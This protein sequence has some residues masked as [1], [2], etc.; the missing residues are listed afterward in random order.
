[1]LLF[2]VAGGKL[3]DA[4]LTG[5]SDDCPIDRTSA[6]ENRTAFCSHERFPTNSQLRSENTLQARSM[7]SCCSGDGLM[8]SMP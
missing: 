8:N 4:V 6:K 1:M 7:I 5:S 3:A 2:T